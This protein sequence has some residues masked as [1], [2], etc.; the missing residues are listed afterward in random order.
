MLGWSR[1]RQILSYLVTLS[2]R[3]SSMI[4]ALESTLRAHIKPV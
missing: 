3:P 2:S 4:L 1:N